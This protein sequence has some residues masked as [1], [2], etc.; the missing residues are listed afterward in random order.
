MMFSVVVG[1]VCI[2]WVLAGLSEA[3]AGVNRLFRE[4]EYERKLA[5]IN[6]GSNEAN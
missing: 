5:Q 1:I 4:L 6:E 2:I 3:H